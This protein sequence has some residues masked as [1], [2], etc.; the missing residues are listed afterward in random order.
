[1]LLASSASTQA[2]AI[3]RRESATKV[4]CA[5]VVFSGLLPAARCIVAMDW[6]TVGRSRERSTTTL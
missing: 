4:A 2:D 3:K 6:R 1:M 5:D